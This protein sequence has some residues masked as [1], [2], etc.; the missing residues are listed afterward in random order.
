MITSAERVQYAN[1]I[2]TE[3][4]KFSNFLKCLYFG[5]FEK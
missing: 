1:I 5:C 4:I 3:R 2:Y